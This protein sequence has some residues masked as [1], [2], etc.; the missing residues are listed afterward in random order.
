VTVGAEKLLQ[1]SGNNTGSAAVRPYLT[2][3][4]SRRITLAFLPFEAKVKACAMFQYGQASAPA[5]KRYVG[6]RRQQEL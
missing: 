4:C 3:R 6:Q 1:Q 2:R 5:A